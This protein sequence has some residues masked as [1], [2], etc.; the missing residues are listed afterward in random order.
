M[1]ESI[2][3]Y[4]NLLTSV[5][6]FA[7]DYI[8][9]VTNKAS[10]LYNFTLSTDE[11]MWEIFITILFVAAVGLFSY[12]FTIGVVYVLKKTVKMVMI[13]IYA[14]IFLSVFVFVSTIFSSKLNDKYG[15]YIMEKILNMTGN[16]AV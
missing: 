5:S 4:M 11:D 2:L 1:F 7:K 15:Y 16:M 8:E 12:N 14:I 10:L 13:P 6:T 3:K 9:T